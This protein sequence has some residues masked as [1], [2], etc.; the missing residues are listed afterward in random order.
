MAPILNLS[1]ELVTLIAQFVDI[2]DL[3]SFALTCR[4]FYL[5]CKPRL[6]RHHEIKKTLHAVQIGNYMPIEPVRTRFVGG[7]DGRRF[8]DIESLDRYSSANNDCSTRCIQRLATKSPNSLLYPRVLSLGRN[9]EFSLGLASTDDSAAASDFRNCWENHKAFRKDVFGSKHEPTVPRSP[10]VIWDE[11]LAQTCYMLPKVQILK[12]HHWVMPASSRLWKKMVDTSISPSLNPEPHPFQSLQEIHL[13]G[14]DLPHSTSLELLTVL[15]T[16]LPALHTFKGIGLGLPANQWSTSF[17][18]KSGRKSG[19]QNLAMYSSAIPRGFFES[20]ISV[21]SS[22]KSFTYTHQCFNPRPTWSGWYTA[23]LME[24]LELNVRESLMRLE[25]TRPYSCTCKLSLGNGDPF[26]PSL[27]K[28]QCLEEI[29]LD[30]MC[31]CWDPSTG[32]QDPSIEMKRL[33]DF[34]PASIKIVKIIG[35][36]SISELATMFAQLPELKETNYPNLHTIELPDCA[37]LSPAIHAAL[38]KIGVTISMGEQ[39]KTWLGSAITKLRNMKM[40]SI[41]DVSRVPLRRRD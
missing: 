30:G 37:S 31:M 23:E 27:K 40:R 12:L 7:E 38:T 24:L 22:L 26:I 11:M 8:L 18:G 29:S 14:M 15:V 25:L 20:Y 36:L 4:A 1:N 39:A 21:C 9:N 3:D 6:Y 32:L 28:F 19:R 13:V 16:Y 17:H 2:D 35:F 5:N 41:Q 34:L 33:V 10:S